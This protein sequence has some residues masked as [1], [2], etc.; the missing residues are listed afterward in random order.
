MTSSKSSET[1]VL[2]YCTVF[3]LLIINVLAKHF[4]FRTCVLCCAHYEKKKKKTGVFAVFPLTCCISVFYEKRVHKYTIFLFLGEV[5]RKPFKKR[6]FL[7][8]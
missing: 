3:N 8:A 5:T 4:F 7:N 2:L 1:S 6:V